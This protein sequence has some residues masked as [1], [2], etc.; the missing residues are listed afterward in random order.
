MEV[1]VNYDEQ[2]AEAVKVMTDMEK[3]LNSTDI[4]P[5]LR[6]LIKIRASQINGCAFCLNM[7]TKDAKSMGETDQRLHCVAAFR[8][9]DFYTDK[10]KAALELT[11]CIT[12]I[13]VKHVPDEVY[14][15]VRAY[16]EKR[17]M[18]I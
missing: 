15:K 2:S 11:E 4:D 16:F 10:E 8:D 1:R 17:N 5:K 14:N 3:Y 6:E 13:S 9:C 7:H 12:E 18:L